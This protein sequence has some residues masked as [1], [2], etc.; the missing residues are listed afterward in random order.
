MLLLPKGFRMAGTMLHNLVISSFMCAQHQ[1]VFYTIVNF[2]IDFSE[3]TENCYR[4]IHRTDWA[5]D[6]RDGCRGLLEIRETSRVTL[7][8]YDGMNA[9]TL[10]KSMPVGHTL[11]M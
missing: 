9:M 2:R 11:F 4:P 1:V 6:A 3:I 5:R 10:Y 7:S 8:L